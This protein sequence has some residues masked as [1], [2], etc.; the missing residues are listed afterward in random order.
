MPDPEH[1]PQSRAKRM[2]VIAL[3]LGGSVVLLVLVA[4]FALVLLGPHLAAIFVQPNSNAP[5]GK[6]AQTIEATSCQKPPTLT[7]A[8]A[9]RQA[10]KYYDQSESR[11]YG[12]IVVDKVGPVEVVSGIFSCD[13]DLCITYHNYNPPAATLEQQA[14]FQFVLSNFLSGGD[15]YT[16]TPG[17]WKVEAM[18]PSC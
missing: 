2:A 6:A 4:I 18:M 16:G 17:P 15:P 7:S 1:V 11:S 13:L 3:W 8:Q 5:L 9:L 10:V 14:D 12:P